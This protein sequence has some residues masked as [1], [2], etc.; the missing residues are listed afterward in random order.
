MRI[1]VVVDTAWQ[2]SVLRD[3]ADMGIARPMRAINDGDGNRQFPLPPDPHDE[4]VP[5]KDLHTLYAKVLEREGNDSVR[6]FGSHL[7]AALLGNDWQTIRD[8]SPA[9]FE[10]ALT[11]SADDAA[12][13]SLPWE[14]MFAP[15]DQGGKFL[16][17]LTAPSV[18]ITRRV[19]GTTAQASA[20]LAPPRVLVV[21]G[22][23]LSEDV[24]K[25]GAEYL[26]LL[27]EVQNAG[28]FLKTHLLL[29]ATPKKLASVVQWFR[30]TVVHFICHG[31][32]DAGHGK[33]VLL[34]DDKPGD[35]FLAGAQ[36]LHAL[37]KL[38]T[39]EAGDT[40]PQIIVMNACSTATADELRAGRPLATELIK[41]G[42]PIV[43]GMSGRVDDQACR[44]F[45][46]GFYSAMLKGGK[47]GYAA[48]EGRR[49]A[50]R[51]SQYD[52]I[53]RWTGRFPRSSC[54]QAWLSPVCPF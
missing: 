54:R 30:P 3:G 4:V 13:N 51:H 21:V 6:L 28:L 24:I 48:A 41:L 12:L 34:S 36:Q 32:T 37:L 38:H 25:P 9:A 1:D 10:L 23:K 40:W 43:V 11:W 33:L 45:A 50:I 22:T 42:I 46:K 19:A 14:M 47:I 26:G 44:L 16:A 31:V 35:P 39:A 20:I 15:D 18:S 2:V 5:A 49:A 27:R 7:F 29:E 8:K 52:P 17:A 53:T